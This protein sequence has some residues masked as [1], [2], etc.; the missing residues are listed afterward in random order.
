MTP[1]AGPEYSEMNLANLA[2]GGRAVKDF[3]RGS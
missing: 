2:A 1:F 3:R